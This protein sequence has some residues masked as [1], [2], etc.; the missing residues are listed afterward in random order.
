ME[1][2][3]MYNNINEI[4]YDTF[5]IP[6]TP[7]T[8]TPIMLFAVPF[9]GVNK[10]Y[11]QTNQPKGN[12]CPYTQMIIKSVGI[13]FLSNSTVFP[14][15]DDINKIS[16]NCSFTIRKNQTPVFEAPVSAIAGGNQIT[17]SVSNTNATVISV[18]TN[19]ISHIDNM[20]TF[21]PSQTGAGVIQTGIPYILDEILDISFNIENNFTL[22]AGVYV[23]VDLFT[24]ASL[25][26]S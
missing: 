12:Q 21:T 26:V 15:I 5:L 3:K 17:G 1:V 10:F 23:K 13:K 16:K 19:G 14:S 11:W 24:D 25:L 2:K 6:T 20:H 7:Q 9:D 4:L 8:P 22:S 18:A